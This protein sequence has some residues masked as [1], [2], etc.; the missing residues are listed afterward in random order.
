M[1]RITKT[2]L[3]V[4]LPMAV[5][6]WSSH[7]QAHE[8]SQIEP[9]T[10][11]KKELSEPVAHLE[12]VIPLAAALSGRLVVLEKK[13]EG[14]LDLSS[15][16]RECAEVEVDLMDPARQLQQL[17]ESKDYRFTKLAKLKQKLEQE[18]ARI[19]EIS[20]P[21]EKSIR[22][23]DTWRKDW[24][25]EQKHWDA[26]ESSLFKE[27]TLNQLKPIFLKAQGT[28]RKALDL[29]TPK[30]EIMFSVQEKGSL[31]QEKIDALSA[32]LDSFISVKR[33]SVL[34]DPSPP[35]LSPRYFSQF[36]NELWYAVQKSVDEILWPDRQ[37]FDRMGW[38][39]LF[40]AFLSLV[41]IIAVYRNRQSLTNTERWCFLGQNPFSTGLFFGTIATFPFYFYWGIPETWR[42]LNSIIGV[43][44]F[45]LLVVAL[46]QKSWK[47]QFIY[48]IAVVII[49]I[50]LMYTV[51]LPL[52][53]FRLCTVL[54][55]SIGFLFCL[56]WARES[57]RLKESNIYSWLLRLSSLFFLFTII[58][59]LW[60]KEGLAEYLF[61]S[62]IYSISLVLAFG[63]FSYL[64]RG[65]LEWVF[66]T[67]PLRRGKSLYGET[68]IIIHRVA[69]LLDFTLWGFVVFPTLLVIWG[70][71]TNL[72]VAMEGLLTLGFNLGTQ[73]ISVGLVIFAA[74]IFYGS[75]LLS[76]TF[77]KLLMK[78][79]LVKHRVEW[80]VRVSIGRLIHYTLVFVGFLLAL[81]IL[82]FRFTELTI[83]L[84]AFGVGI[85]FGLQSIVNNFISGLI[86]LFE[87]PVRVG[88]TIEL[89]GNWAEIKRIG[90]RSTTVQTFDQADV[91]L[92]N[93][94]LV[95]NQVTN[96][97]LSN[98]Q[99]RLIVPVGVAYG[100]DVILVM[101]TLTS[102]A[103]KNSKVAQTPPPQVL[104]LGFGA[105]S[106]DFEL[107]VWVV[108]VGERLTVKSELHQEIDRS[109][110]EAGIV[111]AFPQ[112][113]V[114]LD[115]TKPL[116][117]R[118]VTE[119]PIADKE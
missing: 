115:G 20:N 57:T 78:E 27:G 43:T 99:A 114:H 72:A 66:H 64:I 89:G 118:M 3:L 51:N 69:F 67:S 82:G 4:L 80:G 32:E 30:L 19:E 47:R 84:S 1:R 7:L 49:G 60:G 71:Y 94:D 117:I 74:G 70:V 56:R 29:I 105:N 77:Q 28:I 93:A 22:L 76:L 73:R 116:E 25:A 10:E 13:I 58:A 109:F 38:V 65:G 44:S 87:R 33:R 5:L 95:T 50:R 61:S 11:T 17:K 23:L 35:M 18:K 86:L 53:L 112:R 8:Q 68:S 34:L 37:F 98:R 15:V 100:S 36:S 106:L 75:Y 110:R 14:M 62:W 21:L 108:D 40:H 63:L 104:F 96:W 101:E 39:I 85:G 42:L 52:P 46:I 102:C 92:P 59:E 2:I 41:V 45:V 81:F 24:L 97:T 26:L 113:D 91:I 103:R 88:D 9:P 54:I 111:I 31:I 48:G 16:E 119:K 90:L 83:L 55:A 12:E 107:R 6:L 79:V